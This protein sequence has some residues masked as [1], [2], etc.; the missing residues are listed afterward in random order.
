MSVGLGISISNTK[1][2]LEALLGVRSSFVRTPKY[3]IYGKTNEKTW[4]HK[5]YQRSMGWLPLLEISMSLYFL[6]TI[7]YA[8]HSG[9]W[10]VLPFLSIFVLGYGYVGIA[11]LLNGLGAR[12]SAGSLDGNQPLLTT[13]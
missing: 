5:K 9:I 2:V 12:Q 8:V 3:A 7:I 13:N 11:S 10:G 6:V 4:K 1:A